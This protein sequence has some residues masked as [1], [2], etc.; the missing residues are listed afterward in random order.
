MVSRS[1]KESSLPVL[2]S[3]FVLENMASEPR[4]RDSERPLVTC[5]QTE[6]HTPGLPQTS[7]RYGHSIQDAEE[8]WNAGVPATGHPSCERTTASRLPSIYRCATA[9]GR[10][11][12]S[13]GVRLAVRTRAGS[14]QLWAITSRSRRQRPG[15]VRHFMHGRAHP[16]LQA[17]ST[18]S[19]SEYTLPPGPRI[20]LLLIHRERN[21]R[22]RETMQRKASAVW[23]RLKDGR[24]RFRRT[25]AS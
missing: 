9:E 25:V 7:H 11:G 18:S 23:K 22:R 15:P 8:P 20:E 4:P 17:F 5:V 21:P 24:A 16:G 3:S 1:G 13:R 2:R 12:A 10:S 19:F 14:C 6:N